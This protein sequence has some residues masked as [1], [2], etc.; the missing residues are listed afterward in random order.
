MGGSVFAAC[1]SAGLQAFPASGNTGS[2]HSKK[3]ID[4]F[5]S[6][7]LKH[8]KIHGFRRAGAWHGLV[9]VRM[10]CACPRLGGAGATSVVCGCHFSHFRGISN[11]RRRA[12]MALGFS[13][14]IRAARVCLA[15]G[16]WS[17]GERQSWPRLV[18]L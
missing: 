8:L 6:N 13:T 14:L 7:A 10:A 18:K 16:T 11:V 12:V 17:K 3:S 2:K 9:H 4:T 1:C 15:L 5:L